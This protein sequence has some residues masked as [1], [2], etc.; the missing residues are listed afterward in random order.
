MDGDAN[1]SSC[2]HHIRCVIDGFEP[3]DIRCLSPYASSRAIYRGP[4][5]TQHYC[6]RASDDI[7]MP[8]PCIS[9]LIIHGVC[10]GIRVLHGRQARISNGERSPDPCKGRCRN[11]RSTRVS[12]SEQAFMRNCRIPPSWGLD[13]R[14]I[15]RLIRWKPESSIS[16]VLICGP[17]PER[18]AA[19]YHYVIPYGA[20]IR[21]MICVSFVSAWERLWS[22]S[23]TAVWIGP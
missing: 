22:S 18:A 11:D 13:Q 9:V 15:C 10:V 6:N 3:L 21:P 20:M 19:N 17:L 1:A 16:I 23:F 2:C 14:M 5:S 8:I 4:C 7:K 12:L